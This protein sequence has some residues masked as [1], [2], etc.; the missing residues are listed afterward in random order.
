VQK[1]ELRSH[2]YATYVTL[3]YGLATMAVFFPVLRYL[4]GWLAGVQPQDSM[5]A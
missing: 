3:R 2:I 1:E 5:S 4:G